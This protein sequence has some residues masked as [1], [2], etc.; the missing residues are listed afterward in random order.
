M[1]KVVMTTEYS[2]NQSNGSIVRVKREVEALKKNN[3]NNVSI[4]D[5][6]NKNTTIPT[7]CLIHA[8]QHTGRFFDK[9]EY[10]SDIHGIAA[11]ETRAKTLEYSYY[12]WKKWGYHVR[13]Y[14]LK[15]L[16]EKIWKNSLHLICASD[17]IYDRVKDIQ[18]ATIVR[19]AV[20]VDEFSPTKCEKLRIAV[21]GP[22]LP[23]TQNYDWGLIR[24]C[25]QKLKDIEFIFIGT[26]D[27]NFREKLNFSNTIFLGKV[28][29]YVEALSSCSVLL[30]PYPKSS[31]IIGSKTKMLEAGACQMPVITT[32]TGALGMPEN[33]L[34]VCKSK[35]EFVEKLQYLKDEKIRR[36]YG[37]KFQEEVE[38]KYNTDIEI[39]KLI[40]VYEEF[41][42]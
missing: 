2:L 38:K 34:I 20:K 12:S 24:Y 22:F 1:N 28:E 19:P 14:Q 35:E 36:D 6:F 25:V 17:A 21:V 39:K 30:S 27:E 26:T 29:N 13:S 7:D 11:L 16:E 10:I 32:P 37:K 23:G 8:Q 5:N 40:K 33:L 9:K 31:H 41:M 42:K 15:K 3:F 4:I 18:S